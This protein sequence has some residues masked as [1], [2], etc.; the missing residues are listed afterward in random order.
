MILND[1]FWLLFEVF[2]ERGVVWYLSVNAGSPFLVYL[3]LDVSTSLIWRRAF[4]IERPIYIPL[5]L[6]AFDEIATPALE[7]LLA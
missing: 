6:A 1:A 4:I 2:V 5:Q 7:E 3:T